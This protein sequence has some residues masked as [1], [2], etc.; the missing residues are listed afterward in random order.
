MKIK[1]YLAVNL[2]LSNALDNRGNT[3]VIYAAIANQFDAIAELLVAGADIN[4][5]NK[6]GVKKLN[7][8][9]QF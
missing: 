4:I 8:L 2:N 9:Y 6:L 1:E 5:R 7:Y 3:P